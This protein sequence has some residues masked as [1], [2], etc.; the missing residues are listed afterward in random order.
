[1]TKLTNLDFG[2][3]LRMAL[4]EWPESI[5]VEERIYYPGNRVH[6]P[7]LWVYP[8]SVSEKY[9]NTAD[10]VIMLNLHDAIDI[11]LM[12]VADY[13]TRVYPKELRESFVRSEFEKI[14]KEK[15]KPEW[16]EPEDLQLIEAY[17]QA[18]DVGA[19]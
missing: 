10:A 1:M 16:W 12:R 3:L 15:I 5:D 9:R 2:F 7:G 19:R 8:E 14:L 11:V 18:N 6:I 4:S 13:C 17:F